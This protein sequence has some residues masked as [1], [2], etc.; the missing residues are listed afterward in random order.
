MSKRRALS[1]RATIR[2]SRPN[3]RNAMVYG[4]RGG[5]RL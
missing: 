3:S 5:I 2:R 1:S 4:Y